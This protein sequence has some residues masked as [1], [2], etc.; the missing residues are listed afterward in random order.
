MDQRVFQ[1]CLSEL[2]PKE[3]EAPPVRSEHPYWDK[4]K[5]VGK[6]ALG[7]GLGAAG[8]Y[9]LGEGLNRAYQK[10][11]GSPPSAEHLGRAMAAVGVLSGVAYTMYKRKLD[12]ELANVDGPAPHAVP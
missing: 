5:I 12:E 11:M 7:I 10:T 6:A 9:A 4:T 1:I 3:A 2:M 8:G